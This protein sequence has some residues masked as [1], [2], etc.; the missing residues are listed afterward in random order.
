MPRLQVVEMLPG[1]HEDGHH[2]WAEGAQKGDDCKKCDK[3]DDCNGKLEENSRDEQAFFSLNQTT[4]IKI[5]TN[6]EK[7]RRE[8][9]ILTY[10]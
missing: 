10:L 4:S 9:V 5:G 1:W 7:R 6:E 3:V 8:H 2:Q